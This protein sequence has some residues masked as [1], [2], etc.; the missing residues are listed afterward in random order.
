MKHFTIIAGLAIFL[1]AA[2]VAVASD[3]DSSVSD[4]VWQWSSEV[5]SINDGSSANSHPR[6]FLWIP[7]NCQRVRA[8]VFAQNNMIEEGILQHPKF[9]VAMAKLGIAELFVAPTFD[10]WQVATNNGAV[11]AKFNGLLKTLAAESGYAELEFAPIIPMGHSASASMPWN[12]AAWNSARTL[13]ILS[14][15][16]DAPQT[17]LTGN[18]RPNLDWGGRNIDG[19]PGLMVMAEYEWLEERLAPLPKFLAAHPATPITQL[20]L[21]GCG[22]FDFNEERLIDYLTRFIAKAAGTRLTSSSVL[23]PIDP[24]DG[25]LVDRWRRDDEPRAKVAKFTKFSGDKSEA[26][27]AFD[28]EMARLTEKFN[29]SQ[30]RK[31]PQL[32]GFVQDGKVLKQSDTHNQVLLNFEP[33]ADGLTF[34]LATAFLETVDGGSHNPPRWTGLPAGAPLGHATGGGEIR[35]SRICGPVEQL[36]ANTFA[37]RFNRSA[38]PTDRRAGDIW[39]LAEHSGDV[40]YKSA[41]QQAL[42]KI[43]L[44][45]KDGAEQHITFLAIADV[46]SS[47]AKIKLAAFSDAGVPVKYFVR[48]GPAEIVGDELKLT[49]IPPHAKFPVKVTVVAW[50]YGRAIEPKL[51]SAEPVERSFVITK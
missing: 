21:P 12:F 30:H 24:R 6:A 47:T 39:L 1:V 4:A 37:V 3:V 22:H 40:K 25:W 33:D 44:Q 38:M 36:G 19:I 23:K 18:G 28:G 8:V 9:R 5:L 46:K 29:A 2:N 42:L 17:T 45:L 16:G 7:P 32:L 34:H 15:K 10:Y 43:P 20:P 26:F 35:L 48:E 14:V 13:A 11:N 49:K 31:L 50:Q 41:V 51:K 27:W